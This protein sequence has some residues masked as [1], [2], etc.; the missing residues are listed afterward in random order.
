MESKVQ[1]IWGPLSAKEYGI[2]HWALKGDSI[3]EVCQ[4]WNVTGFMVGRSLWGPNPM[5]CIVWL[6][7]LIWVK[8]SGTF[9][10]TDICVLKLGKQIFEDTCWTGTF[11]VTIKWLKLRVVNKRSV[12]PECTR[13]QDSNSSGQK[14]LFFWRLWGRVFYSPGRPL[15][16]F[17][18]SGLALELSL[19][20]SLVLPV[21]GFVS[22]PKLPLCIK[23]EVDHIGLDSILLTLP[24][25]GLLRWLYF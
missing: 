1:L 15:V 11:D 4:H 22:R 23:T 18:R 7:L 21:L 2:R 5:K 10:I 24:W 20:P 3:L 19:S 17:W 25:L 14:T 8:A 16:L 12:L 6:F 13:G 9:P